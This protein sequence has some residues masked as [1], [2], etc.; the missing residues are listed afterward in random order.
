MAAARNAVDNRTRLEILRLVAEL[1]DM[2]NPVGAETLVAGLAERGIAITV[3]GVRWHLRF[4]D[5][6]GFTRRVGTRGRMVTEAGWRELQRS[7]VDARMMYARARTET[8]AHQVTLD[9]GSGNGEVVGA[10]TVFPAADLTR[11]LRHAALACRA[12][13]C[14]SDRVAVV[15]GG[16][17]L[18]ASLIPAGKM[19]L[20][21]VSTATIDGLLLSRGI[22]FNPTYGGVVE[23]SGWRPQRFVDILEYGR[24]SRDPVEVLVRSGSTSLTGMLQTGQGLIMADVREVVGVARDRACRLLEGMSRCG[25]G[26]VL[27]VGQVGQPVLGVPVQQ[28]TF[29]IALVAGINA[30]VA[31]FEAGV[32]AEFHCSEAMV[33]YTSIRPVGELIPGVGQVR[34]TPNGILAAMT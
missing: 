28:H 14:V 26:G 27:M 1:A 5:Q 30:T 32:P 9:T 18:G 31:A 19:G 7:L 2:D 15:R 3:D 20:I 16:E 34:P 29:G 22:G 17:K 24:G 13:F 10:L 25:L 11:V 33:Q 6:Q 8:L 21:T 23:L 12:G 4:L